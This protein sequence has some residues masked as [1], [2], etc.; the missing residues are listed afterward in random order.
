MWDV[1]CDVYLTDS[2]TELQKKKQSAEDKGRNTECVS[3]AGY[4]HRGFHLPL[5]RAYFSNDPIP[6]IALLHWGLDSSS[7]LIL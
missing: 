6:L 4:S 5:T 1:M 2:W 3:T 7:A